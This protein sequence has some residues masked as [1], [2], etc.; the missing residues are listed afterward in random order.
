[1]VKVEVEIPK[2][3]SKKEKGGK[4][5]TILMTS[6]K[7]KKKKAKRVACPTGMLLALGEIKKKKE[8]TFIRR[9][10]KKKTV[11]KI[12]NQRKKLKE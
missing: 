3:D 4:I 11:K 12:K 2:V 5:R 6:L 10:S 8:K 1:M 9:T 7:L